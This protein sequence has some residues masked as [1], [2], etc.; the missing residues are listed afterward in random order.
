MLSEYFIYR[1]KIISIIL[2]L[3]RVLVM[4][5]GNEIGTIYYLTSVETICYSEDGNYAILLFSNEEGAIEY[6]RLSI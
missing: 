2:V 6:Y 1:V 3:K 5:V 4:S